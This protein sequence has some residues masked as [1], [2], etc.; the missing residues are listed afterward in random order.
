MTVR[1]MV[2]VEVVVVVVVGVSI[3]VSEGEMGVG[4]LFGRLSEDG[5][6]ARAAKVR[7]REV[8]RGKKVERRIVLC[9]EVIWWWVDSDVT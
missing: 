4:V 2:V 3:G 7:A 1:R 6:G 5:V 9:G 8:R